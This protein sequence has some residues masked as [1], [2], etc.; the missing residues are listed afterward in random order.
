[1]LDRGVNDGLKLDKQQHLVPIIGVGDDADLLAA[2]AGH[3]GVD[4]EAVKGFDLVLTDTHKPATIGIDDEFFA[5]PRLDNLVSVHAGLRA[6]L[7]A[8][9]DKITVLAA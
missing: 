2:V 6:L 1:H 5:A 7:E 3:A 9:S 4:P 8:E